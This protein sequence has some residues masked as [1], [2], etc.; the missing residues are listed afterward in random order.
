MALDSIKTHG[1]FMVFFSH[2][3]GTQMEPPTGRSRPAQQRG[4][5][6]MVVAV[7]INLKRS[8]VF[9]GLTSFRDLQSDFW[10]HTHTYIYIYMYIYIYVDITYILHIYVIYIYIYIYIL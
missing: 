3:S 1:S 4:I 9:L 2:G 6:G 5:V 10:R 8:P 7:A